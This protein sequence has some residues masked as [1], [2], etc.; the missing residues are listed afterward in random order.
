MNRGQ[1]IASLAIVLLLVAMGVAW[2]TLGGDATLA[3]LDQLESQLRESESLSEDQREQITNE[4]REVRQ[5]LTEDQL[6]A[7]GEQRRQQFQNQMRERITKYFEMP[8]E[9]RVAYLDSEIDRFE[10]RRS[11]WEQRR[12]ERESN[13][14]NT[15]NPPTAGNAG[16]RGMGPRGGP[17]GGGGPPSQERRMERRR[18]MLDATSPE[19][20]A[21]FVAFME[22]MKQ[23]REERGL[24]TDWGRG[25]PRR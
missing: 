3:R 14:S 11:Q 10:E 12:R 15:R 20:R 21:M 8:E 1:K 17:G 7:Y 6:R 13:R 9:Q 22:D 2:Y 24:T 23:R 18:R 16:T 4:I 25:G 5:G 19:D